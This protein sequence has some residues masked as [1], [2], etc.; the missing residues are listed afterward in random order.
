[1]ARVITGASSARLLARHLDANGSVVVGK[2]EILRLHP[3]WEVVL[4]VDDVHTVESQVTVTDVH[5]SQAHS[6]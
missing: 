3:T 6:P 5:Q 2:G 1:M 4:L